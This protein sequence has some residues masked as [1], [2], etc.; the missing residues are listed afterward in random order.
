MGD[1]NVGREWELKKISSELVAKFWIWLF[2]VNFEI[3]KTEKFIINRNES[4]CPTHPQIYRSIYYQ[5]NAKL[6]GANFRREVVGGSNGGGGQVLV[7]PE[8]PRDAKIAHF[9]QILTRQKDVLRLQI[10]ENTYT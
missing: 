7:A 9:H 1:K 4:I 10:F 2:H 8:E 5:Y 3:I 6:P